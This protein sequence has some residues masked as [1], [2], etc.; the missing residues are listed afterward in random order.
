MHCRARRSLPSRR[1]PWLGRRR[2]HH[3]HLQRQPRRRRLG[4]LHHRQGH[5]THQPLRAQSLRG[6]RQRH[7]RRHSHS[8]H[9]QW[10]RQFHKGN[11]GRGPFPP[12]PRLYHGVAGGVPSTS[13]PPMP[14]PTLFSH[15]C[16]D[17]S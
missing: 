17:N 3:N 12:P 16:L 9:R 2:G 11:E 15:F 5:Q 14:F 1:Q 8:G 4:R 10:E 7:S 13:S 6:P